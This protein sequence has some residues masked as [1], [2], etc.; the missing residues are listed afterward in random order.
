MPYRFGMRQ[1]GDEN[2]TINITL[3]NNVLPIQKPQEVRKVPGGKN[4]KVTISKIKL[5]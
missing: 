5:K 1:V 3:D 4:K 2:D